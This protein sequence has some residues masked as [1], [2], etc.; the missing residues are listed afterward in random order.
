M[1]TIRTERDG[2]AELRAWYLR[3]LRPKLADAV[4]AGKVAPA[5]AE[6][7]DR[8]LREFLQLAG[9]GPR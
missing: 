7:L 4:D 6:A 9:E 1:A 2:R 8:Q 5:A 3:G